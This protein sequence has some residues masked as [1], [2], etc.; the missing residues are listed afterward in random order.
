MERCIVRTVSAMDARVSP[1]LGLAALYYPRGPSNRLQR[2]PAESDSGWHGR[3]SVSLWGRSAARVETA[4]HPEERRYPS[5]GHNH[6]CGICPR[7]RNPRS[8]RCSVTSVR[9][10]SRASGAAVPSAHCGLWPQT[11]RARFHAHG[12]WR[13]APS[14][15]AK[16]RAG[17]PRSDGARPRAER[18]GH[19]DGEVRDG[20][21]RKNEGA[22]AAQTELTPGMHGWQ[23]A[24]APDSRGLARG[25]QGASRGGTEVWARRRCA[26]RRCGGRSDARAP[27]QR[28]LAVVRAARVECG[29]GRA[30]G[31]GRTRRAEGEEGAGPGALATARRAARG[32]GRLESVT[33]VGHWSRSLES[34]TGVR[35]RV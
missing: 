35:V 34:V 33:G 15:G 32:R 19:A 8:A 31:V 21:K 7:G 13:R 10:P 1:R 9:G 23:A 27:S 25:V 20:Q 11:G 24:S 26:T 18:Q 5:N 14:R 22:Q 30:H 2:G 3:K 6:K 12:D 28:P 4:Q 16:P 29:G 17:S